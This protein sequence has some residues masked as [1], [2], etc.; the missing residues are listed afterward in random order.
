[1]PCDGDA[2][3]MTDLSP[4]VRFLTNLRTMPYGKFSISSSSAKLCGCFRTTSAAV[5]LTL[6][7][8]IR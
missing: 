6:S 5:V 3:Y 8:A 4:I 2:P 7:V 1:M